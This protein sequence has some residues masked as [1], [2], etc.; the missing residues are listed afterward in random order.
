[1]KTFKS[2]LRF[3]TILSVLGSLGWVG[4]ASAVGTIFDVIAALVS[5]NLFLSLL[6]YLERK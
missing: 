5:A 4:Y 3:A 1:M 6:T 2:V